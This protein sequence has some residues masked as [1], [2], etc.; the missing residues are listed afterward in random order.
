MIGVVVGGFF[1]ATAGYFGGL[2]DTI[3]MRVI[4]IN[5][6]IPVLLLAVALSAALG[7]GVVSTG[8]QPWGLSSITG[9]A[10][11]CAPTV[12]FR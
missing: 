11:S 1:G 5:T 4:D 12:N 9:G 6:S 3:V 10:R 7:T 2:Y 8:A